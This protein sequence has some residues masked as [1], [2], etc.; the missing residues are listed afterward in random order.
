[1][2]TIDLYCTSAG[3]IYTACRAQCFM[4]AEGEE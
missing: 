1:L 4:G 2:S 3:D